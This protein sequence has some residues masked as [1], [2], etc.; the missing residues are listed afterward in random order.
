[1][2]L[3]WLGLR[4]TEGVWYREQKNEQEEVSYT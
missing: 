2:V 4:R 1:M 3:S